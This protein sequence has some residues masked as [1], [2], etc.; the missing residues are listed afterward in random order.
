M[1]TLNHLFDLPEQI[2]YVECGF[3]TTI[4]MPNEGSSED[5][6]ACK[7]LKNYSSSVVTYSDCEEENTPQTSSVVNKPP[8]KRQR[9]PSA[10][11]CFIKEEIKRLKAE[12]PKMAHREAFST[13]AKNWA[14][15]PPSHCKGE[16]DS[17]KILHLDCHVESPNASQVTTLKIFNFST[18][19]SLLESNITDPELLFK[20]SLRVA[21]DELSKLSNFPSKLRANAEH[22]ARL[23]KAI[24]VYSSV[25]GDALDRLND[26]ISALGTVT[27][28]IVSSTSVNNVEM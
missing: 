25:I 12:N 22:D 5:G 20:L 3:C 2:C 27:G 18:I 7:T 1:S 17:C 16:A 28:R 21:I 24:N 4:L 23:Q 19:S 13:A 9:T 8:E 6:A 26:S 10:Y 11:N 14:N 15:F